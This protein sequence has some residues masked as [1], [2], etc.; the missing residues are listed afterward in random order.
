MYYYGT[1]SDEPLRYFACGNLM[2]RDGFVHC[3]RVLNSNVLIFVLEG[4]LEITV[5]G[6][7]YSVSEGEFIFLK[8]GGEHFG[9]KPS[10]GNLSYLW[11]HFKSDSDW[12]CFSEEDIR[13]RK[14]SYLLPE[15]GR[16]AS[17]QRVSMLFRQLIDF[18]RQENIYS[19]KILSYAVSLLIMELTQEAV[20]T[21]SQYSENISP[22]VSDASEWIRSNCHRSISLNEIADE[23][24]YNAEYL[25]SLFKKETG[26][27]LK[28]YLIRS[29]I[30]VAKNLL[31]NNNL[32]IKE[33]AYSSGFNDEKYFMKM[34]RKYE[35]ITPTQYKNA[36]HR[37]LINS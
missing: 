32:S 19:E 33:A 25:S 1:S 30:E 2:S 7:E 4:T 14:L 12:E 8:S 16:A 15:Y 36:F 13:S 17:F 29:R 34:F 26:L 18:S 10:S 21:I 20:D 5:S 6:R 24:H 11:V 31:A 22:V 27:S 28:S 9:T 35:G 23:F 3:R 37:R